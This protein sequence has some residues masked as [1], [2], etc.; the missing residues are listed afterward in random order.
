LREIP[1]SELEP[2]I[3]YLRE[4]YPK[5]DH[6]TAMAKARADYRTDGKI[7]SRA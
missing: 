3:K 6:L 5:M 1:A 2:V 7:R 4:R